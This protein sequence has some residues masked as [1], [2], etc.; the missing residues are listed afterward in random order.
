MSA[1][2]ERSP[3]LHGP[4]IYRKVWSC[5]KKDR[6][7]SVNLQTCH[8]AKVFEYWRNHSLSWMSPASEL[9]WQAGAF[10]YLVLSIDVVS[11]Y[12]NE[13]NVLHARACPHPLGC[14]WAKVEIILPR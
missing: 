9:N 13:A 7:L 1:F 8:V 2:L 5:R 3:M 10:S 12:K 14:S 4:S 6:H 11:L